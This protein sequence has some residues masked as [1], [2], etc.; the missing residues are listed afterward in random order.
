[1]A[2]RA[3]ELGLSLRAHTDQLSNFGATRRA[4]ELGALSCDHLEYARESDV[5]AMAASGS[6]A[7]LLPGAF[8]FLRERRKPPINLFRRHGVPLAI[9]T[10]INPGSS[11]IA[12]LLAIL[13]MA[14]IFFGLTPEETLLGVTKNAARALGRENNIGVL[15]PG[16]QADFTLW[17][18]P[19]PEMLCYQLGGLKPDA[20][21]HQG[22]TI[23]S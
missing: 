16:A 8:Y 11:P 2:Q 6:V 10:D 21:Y 15:K 17:N 4:A 9:A 3:A 23:Y 14:G 1:L 5:V 20:V 22:R 7:V 12:S 18:L 19:A 13:H